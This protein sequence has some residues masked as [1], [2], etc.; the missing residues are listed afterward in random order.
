MTRIFC[1]SGSLLW[2]EC[3]WSIDGVMKSFFMHDLPSLARGRFLLSG[4]WRVV[5]GRQSCQ[6]AATE[7]WR[8]LFPTAAGTFTTTYILCSSEYE[9]LLGKT[10]LLI[11]KAFYKPFTGLWLMIQSRWLSKEVFLILPTE[12]CLFSVSKVY[13]PYVTWEGSVASCAAT[14]EI[15]KC[16]K[17]LLG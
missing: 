12:Q 14:A 6:K 7:K 3:R 4:S 15:F 5:G 8:F 1:F 17:R 10:I 2:L 9:T 13:L 16:K 11:F